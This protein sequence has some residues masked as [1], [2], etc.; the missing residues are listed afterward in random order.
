MQGDKIFIRDRRF[1]FAAK[2]DLETVGE[3]TGLQDVAGK[4]IYEGDIVYVINDDTVSTVEFAGGSFVVFE[5]I[6]LFEFYKQC[7]VVGNIHD[8]PELLKESD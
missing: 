2:V 4:D 5:D 3:F 7:R 8:N 1:E 6:E